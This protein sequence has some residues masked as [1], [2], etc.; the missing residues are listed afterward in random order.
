MKMKYE[1]AIVMLAL[2][3]SGFLSAYIIYSIVQLVI[4]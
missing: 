4:A 1:R 2:I 3:G